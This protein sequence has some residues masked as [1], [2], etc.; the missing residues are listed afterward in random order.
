M[1]NNGAYEKVTRQMVISI[2]E[3]IDELKSE[4]KIV[5]NHMSTRLPW[6]ATGLIA[7]LT[8]LSSALIVRGI[9]A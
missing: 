6:W 2:K 7:T 5:F 8:S 4:V 9:Y 3:D 1:V